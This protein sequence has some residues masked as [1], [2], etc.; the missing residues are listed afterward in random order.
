MKSENEELDKEFLYISF[1]CLAV[2]GIF[3]FV[4]EQVAIIPLIITLI[5]FT[6]FYFQAIGFYARTDENPAFMIG[7]IAAINAVEGLTGLMLGAAW[8]GYILLIATVL[9][10]VYGLYTWDKHKED[11]RITPLPSN[12]TNNEIHQVDDDDPLGVK[13]YANRVRPR[14]DGKSKTSR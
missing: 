12:Q 1:F 4:H 7:L 10:V 11:T 13:P 14:T 8:L 9:M 2:T 5:S 6:F 3:V